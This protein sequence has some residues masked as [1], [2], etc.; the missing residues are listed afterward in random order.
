[1]PAFVTDG[2]CIMPSS[3]FLYEKKDERKC[4]Y[5]YGASCVSVLWLAG[6]RKR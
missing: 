3:A 2:L 6:N 4:C 1:M 5:G